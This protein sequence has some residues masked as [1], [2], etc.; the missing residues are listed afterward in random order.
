MI[1]WWTDQSL[2]FIMSGGG[3]CQIPLSGP[4]VS[5]SFSP[6]VSVQSEQSEK[7]VQRSVS[8]PEMDLHLGSATQTM[9][10]SCSWL[11]ISWIMMSLWMWSD[12]N[13]CLTHQ[14]AMHPSFTCLWVPWHIRVF[15][16]ETPTRKVENLHLCLIRRPMHVMQFVICVFVILIHVP[17]RR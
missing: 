15:C 12:L 11:W 5:S 8:F 2:Y 7:C 14:G 9:M 13:T 17:L 4:T 16:K 10:L 1:L 3:F 6:V